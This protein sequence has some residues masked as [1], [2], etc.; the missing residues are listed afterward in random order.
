MRLTSL[1]PPYWRHALRLGGSVALAALA[2]ST[3]PLGAEQ[4]TWEPGA[5]S[6]AAGHVLAERFAGHASGQRLAQGMTGQRGEERLPWADGSDAAR[7]QRAADEA[8]LQAK[9]RAEKEQE[10]IKEAAEDADRQRKADKAAE[11]AERKAR[12]AAEKKAAEQTG[13]TPAANSAPA[14]GTVQDT[15]AAE[16]RRAEAAARQAAADAQAAKASAEAKAAETKAAEAKVAAEKAEADRKA[17]EAAEAAEDARR[18]AERTAEERRLAD[19]R[20]RLAADREAEDRQLSDKLRRSREAITAREAAPAARDASGPSDARPSGSM[21]PEGPPPEVTQSPPPRPAVG[22][23][24]AATH[25]TVLLVI[26]HGKRGIRRFD[27]TGDPLLCVGPDCYAGQGARLGTAEPARRMARFAAFSPGNTLGKR[28]FACS[29]SLAC[30]YRE[31]DLGTA[32]AEIQPVDMRILR[33]DRREPMTVA[34]DDT[35]AVRA[36]RL[37]CAQVV[38]SDSWRAW[39]VP[40]RVAREA[41]PAVL[42]QALE[43]LASPSQAALP[44][45]RR[46]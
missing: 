29:K 22:S 14:A 9:A 27:R 12:K 26:E 8:E 23:E 40:E 2:L 33:H 42:A 11:A 30:A 21:P 6:D 24:P 17:A 19:E 3:P 15:Q 35:C 32:R 10:A 37:T 38:I 43:A 34:A 44:S 46:R 36:G 39:I 5:A 20:A 28:A 31:V 4:A 7:A 45:L 13:G 41:G 25:V 18:R 16:S 1:R